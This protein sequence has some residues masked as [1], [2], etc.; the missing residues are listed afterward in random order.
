MRDRSRASCLEGTD[1]LVGSSGSDA[2]VGAAGRAN[3]HSG[4]YDDTYLIHGAVDTIVEARGSGTD[5]VKSSVA[6]TP[7]SNVQTLA[8][9]RSVGIGSTGNTLAGIRTGNAGDIALSGGTGDD[10]LLGVKI[11]TP[12]TAEAT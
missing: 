12:S 5:M 1:T 2:L 4:V 6:L 8:L 3:L 11:A 9:T 10:A 7:R